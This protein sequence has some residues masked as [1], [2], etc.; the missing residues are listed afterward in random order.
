MYG[1]YADQLGWFEGGLRGQWGGSPNWQSHGLC[2]GIG[3][4]PNLGKMEDLLLWPRTAK[5]GSTGRPIE[6]QTL[7]PVRR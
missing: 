3:E 7:R 1:I 4:S 5:L 6:G 2:L